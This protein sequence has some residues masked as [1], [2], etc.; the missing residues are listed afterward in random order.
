MTGHSDPGRLLELA[1]AIARD[2]AIGETA[3]E[4]VVVALPDAGP[5]VPLFIETDGEPVS[6][7]GLDRATGAFLAALGVRR[8][9]RIGETGLDLPGLPPAAETLV[10]TVGDGQHQRRALLRLWRDTTGLISSLE[11]V[12]HLLE[13]EAPCA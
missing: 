1:M 3:V 13:L 4:A 9:I 7:A 10:C 2:A 8:W 5:P 11:D 12:T 6:L